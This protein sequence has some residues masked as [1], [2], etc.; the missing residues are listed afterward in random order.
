MQIGRIF[1]TGLILTALCGCTGKDSHTV[2]ITGYLR[3]FKRGDSVTY[4]LP[5][6]GY[7]NFRLY[8]RTPVLNDSGLFVLRGELDTTGFIKI[9][10]RS[11]RIYI[12][13]SAGDQI[14]LKENVTQ[15]NGKLD[16]P[17][18]FQG[19]NWQALT[20]YNDLNRDI[21]AKFVFAEG[22]LQ[23]KFAHGCNFYDSLLSGINEYLRP[24]EALK[25]KG[26][27]SPLYYNVIKRDMTAIMFHHLI[28][29]LSLIKENNSWMDDRTVND[30]RQLIRMRYLTEVIN[31]DPY[32]LKAN[33]GQAIVSDFEDACRDGLQNG[34]YPVQDTFLYNHGNVYRYAS[35][36]NN[37][38]GKFEWGSILV[39]EAIGRGGEIQFDSIFNYYK[40]KYPG[41]AYTKLIDTFLQHQQN[42]TADATTNHIDSNLIHIVDSSRKIKSLEKLM[43]NFKG[44]PVMI[45][46]W[47]TWCMPCKQ[48][49]AFKNQVAGILKDLNADLLYVSIDDKAFKKQ[50]VNDIYQLGLAGYHV[51]ASAELQR[52]IAWEVYHIT[53][54]RMLIPRYILFDANGRLVNDSLPRPSNSP[55]LKKILMQ[56]LHPIS[57]PNPTRSH[58]VSPH[59]PL[60]TH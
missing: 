10:T 6:D 11:N 24:L 47:A 55:S 2:T 16:F 36:L 51:N 42:T 54:N 13:A 33:F 37:E 18:S 35:R 23:R 43:T 34:G 29:N 39:T 21:M 41:A 31:K 46:L 57:T 28:R 58:P 17:V 22:L 14:K 48:E 3:D 38:W 20:V 53:N 4:Y 45:D 5:V 8:K 30:V 7:S 9:Q 60:S 32:L 40:K 15:L 19:N 52:D 50:W 27:I 12:L 1:L 56:E 44:R 26:D 59:Q 49:F 25:E